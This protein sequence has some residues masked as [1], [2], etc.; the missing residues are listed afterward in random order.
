MTEFT[1][2]RLSAESGLI[3]VTVHDFLRSVPAHNE[4]K[5]IF[6]G[7]WLIIAWCADRQ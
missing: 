1:Y 2:S 6:S 4:I 5:Q 7:S 3:T